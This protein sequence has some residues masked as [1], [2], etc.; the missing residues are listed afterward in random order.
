MSRSTEFALTPTECNFC[1]SEWM[2]VNGLFVYYLDYPNKAWTVGTADDLPALASLH[3]TIG[4]ILGPRTPL[5][6][7]GFSSMADLI[8]LGFISLHIPYFI[9]DTYLACGRF[10]IRI[11]N[12]REQVLLD[13]E[14]SA[15]SAN[16]MSLKRYMGSL[17][18]SKVTEVAFGTEVKVGKKFLV[19]DGAREWVHS[20]GI[21]CGSVQKEIVYIP[22]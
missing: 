8:D 22:E 12:L 21:L 14:K 20:G 13:A 3:Q 17:F 18:S 5:P 11:P 9:H 7:N 4:L 10:A 1:V 16:Y 19:S 6:L 2:R 15:R